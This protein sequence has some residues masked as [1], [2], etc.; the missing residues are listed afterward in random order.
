MAWGLDGAAALLWAVALAGVVWP[1]RNRTFLLAL[2]EHPALENLVGFAVLVLP[3]TVAFAWAEHRWGATPGKRL[4][5]LHVVARTGRSAPSARQALARN[6]VKV[7]L[8]WAIGHAAVFLLVHDAD[9]AHG[10]AAPG[11]PAIGLLVL[12]YVLPIVTLVGVFAG[13]RALH[14]VVAGTEV[15]TGR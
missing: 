9:V 1:Q 15:V 2:S 5:G 11:A 14:D 6:G 13:G 4:T 3:V 8:P 10:A 7:A 12:S